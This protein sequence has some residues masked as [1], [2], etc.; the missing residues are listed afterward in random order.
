V[1]VEVRDDGVG[2]DP[3][4]GD[5]RGHYGLLGL[6]ERARLAGGSLDVH[7]GPDGGVTLRLSLPSAAA[8]TVARVERRE[9]T[10]GGEI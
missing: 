5:A 1:D 8:E 10:S 4:A 7:N 9:R 6:R 3:A 2:F